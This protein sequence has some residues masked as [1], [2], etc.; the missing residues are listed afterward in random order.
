[1]STLP[2]LVMCGTCDTRKPRKHI[3]YFI[4]LSIKKQLIRLLSVPGI[5]ALLQHRDNRQKLNIDASEDVFDSE[6]FRALQERE[7]YTRP[8]DFSY[9]FD[10][11]GFSVSKSSNTEAHPI[12]FRINEFAPALRQKMTLLAGVWLDDQ[13]PDFNLFFDVF[14]RE[15]NTL[16][17]EGIRWIP[18][19][20]E[21]V[22]SRF[23]PCAFCADAKARAS[24]MNF[25]HHSGKFSCPYCIHPGVYLNR[26]K[27]PLPGTQVVVPHR[28]G[29]ERV[30]IIPEDIP[31]RT[32]AGVR[33][34]MQQA[35]LL[36]RKIHGI[37]G[38]SVL[39]NLRH[40]HLGYGCSPDDLHPVYLG[41]TRFLTNLIINEVNNTDALLRHVDRILMNIRTPTLMSRKPR[42][43]ARR[44][45]WK[46]TEW[47][48]WL[49]YYGVVCLHGYQP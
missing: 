44:N 36:Q 13:E 8:Y 49:L 15:A 42:S 3:K 34:D 5:W 45:K 26:M 2:R 20:D 1:M 18:E 27:F 33:A 14:V 38:V 4:T 9:F 40:F 37:K 17:Q 10:N 48:N 22:V 47:R 31:L 30:V 7:G 24:V 6:G 39:M 43:I 16:S 35:T 41:V 29:G 21:E 28:N 23:F 32:D 19:G 12:F 46:G 11:D 25:N